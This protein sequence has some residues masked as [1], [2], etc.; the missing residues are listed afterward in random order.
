MLEKNIALENKTILITGAAG[1][2]GAALTCSLLER[3]S[4]LQVIGVDN[5][6]S[7]YDVSLKN[8]RLDKVREMAENS[9][10]TFIFER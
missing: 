2:I 5:L 6:N 9:A 3:N 10:G 8:R 1:F 4:R 7:Y